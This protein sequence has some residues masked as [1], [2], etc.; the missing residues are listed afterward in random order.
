MKTNN[1]YKKNDNISEE[2]YLVYADVG[3]FV[4]ENIDRGYTVE[5]KRGS[6][7]GYDLFTYFKHKIVIK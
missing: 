5:G 6:N 2:R 3:Q 1:N 4:C 7:G